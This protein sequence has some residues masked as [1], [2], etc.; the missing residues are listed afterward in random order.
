MLVSCLAYFSTQKIEAICSS[1]TS[2]DFHRTTLRYISED[3]T[4]HIRNCSAAV[5]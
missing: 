2:V 1:E 3:V 5:T 4:L